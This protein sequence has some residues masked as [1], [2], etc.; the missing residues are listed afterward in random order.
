MS[1]REA[2]TVQQSLG[3]INLNFI[4]FFT[5]VAKT[6]IVIFRIKYVKNARLKVKA[7]NLRPTKIYEF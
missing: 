3:T 2:A 1:N 5:G 7:Y 4:A 6:V